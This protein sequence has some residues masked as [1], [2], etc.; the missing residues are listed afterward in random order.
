MKKIRQNPIVA[1]AAQNKMLEEVV[2]LPVTAVQQKLH[3]EGF[4]FDEWNKIGG[5][6]IKKPLK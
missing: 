3:K 1:N 4:T 5:E 2:T 6:W